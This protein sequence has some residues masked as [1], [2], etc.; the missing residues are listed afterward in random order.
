MRG[1]GKQLGLSGQVVWGVIGG[2]SPYAA[3]ALKAVQF[4]TSYHFPGF[5]LAFYLVLALSA[6]LGVVGSVLLESH[7][8]F[9][10]WF[11]GGSFPIMLNFLFGE[12]LHQVGTTLHSP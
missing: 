1:G 2:L 12:A 7:T 4:Q 6:A 11:H 3:A 5:S 8:K 9:T 10:A